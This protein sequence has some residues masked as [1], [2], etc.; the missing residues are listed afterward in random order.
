MLGRE[1][2]EADTVESAG[3]AVTGVDRVFVEAREH[4]CAV[5]LV[6]AVLEEA[7]ELLARQE[8]RLLVVRKE[9]RDRVL[10]R[11]VTAPFVANTSNKTQQRIDVLF[12]LL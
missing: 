2:I 1:D 11:H 6:L 12:V 3:N 7:D 10:L 4:A 9:Q 8:R 5:Q